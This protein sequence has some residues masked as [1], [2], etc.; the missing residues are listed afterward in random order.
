M[1]TVLLIFFAYLC[2]SVPF[3]KLIG[4]AHGIDIQR[5]GSGNIGFA[6]VRRVLGWRAGLLT[7]AGDIAKGALPAYLAVL[8]VSRVAAFWVGLSAIAGHLF[9]VWLRFRGGKGIA[10]GL[11]M[12]CVLQP[13]PAAIGAGVYIAG[14]LIF[15]NSAV[16]SLAGVLC[17]AIA[18]SAL[19]PANWWRFALLLCIALWTLRKNLAGTVPN[20][21]I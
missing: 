2:G 13:V 3:G 12:L 4:R 16:S 9:P 18:G 20:Y 15:R 21:D 1:N 5:R 8:T 11:G 19:A 7:L 14:C 17:L 6:N 10:T